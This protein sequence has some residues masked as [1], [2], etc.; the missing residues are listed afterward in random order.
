MRQADSVSTP[1]SNA[2][3]LALDLAAV[4]LVAAA[5]AMLAARLEVTLLALSL[6]L[7]G[8]GVRAA[9]YRAR[10]IKTPL[11][12]P[13]LAFLL[14]T[15]MSAGI[16]FDPIAA[17]HK[18]WLIFAGIALYFV[19]VTLKTILAIRIVIWGLLLI[20]VG[21]GFYYVTQTDFVV[22]PAKFDLANQIGLT[23]HRLTP[24]LGLHTPHPNLIAGIL[25]LGLPFALGETFNAARHKQWGAFGVF[26][27]V[28]LFSLFALF[29]T[30][31]RGAWFAA[32]AVALLGALGYGALRLARRLG[33]SSNLGIAVL[34]NLILLTV[35][36]GVAL[37]GSQ[38][39]RFLDSVFGSVGNVPRLELYTQVWQLIQDYFWTGAGLETFSPMFSTYLLLLD[40]PFLAHSHNLFLQ[41]WFEQG[42]LGFIVFLWVL[43][44]FFLWVLQRRNRMNW[45]ALAGLAAVCMMLLHGLVDVPIY[46]SRVIP[47]MFVPFGL[48][49]AAL[50]PFKAQNPRAALAAR[51]MNLVAL[52]VIAVIGIGFFI[53]EMQ[54][55]NAFHAELEANRGALAQAALELPFVK[56]DDMP[57][58]QVRRQVNLQNAQELYELALSIDPRNRLAHARLGLIALDTLDFTRA[59]KELE[60]AYEADPRH[61]A[62]IK[63][64]GL[65]YV[66]LGQPDKAQVLLK[67]IPEAEIELFHA[68]DKW[69][70]LK[71]PD[72]EEKA[73]AM[74]EQLKR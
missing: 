71:R 19:L 24:Q 64:L 58:A 12:L 8:L 33:Y 48:T 20:C 21:V 54:R 23:L 70:K 65:A 67:Q 66:W 34:V 28:T 68:Q 14:T 61:R 73:A 44:A 37:G 26:A 72:L 29:M 39:S 51:R 69:R 25:L 17:R 7:A 74:L 13:W 38:V 49:L 22:E 6:I 40:V 5:G 4:G 46:F 60:L 2:Q 3:Q 18:L 27:F 36:L 16:A 41:I 56:F 43:G 11:G 62:T 52:G 9:Q 57:P 32:A 53:F 59:V 10:S 47:L 55:P 30:T 63:G 31:S 35:L 50:Q 45:I 1:Q 42:I 15:A